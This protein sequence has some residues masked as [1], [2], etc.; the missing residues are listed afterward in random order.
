[1]LKFVLAIMIS[2]VASIYMTTLS[3]NWSGIKFGFGWVDKS[4]IGKGHGFPFNHIASSLPPVNGLYYTCP[5]SMN[6]LAGR[7]NYLFWLILFLLLFFSI[8][9][10]FFN[11]NG[12][13]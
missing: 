4:C 1:M 7:L 3:S 8:N 13:R 6:P 9:K 2:L 10:L 5:G 11:K 12:K